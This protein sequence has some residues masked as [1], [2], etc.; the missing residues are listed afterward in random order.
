MTG[1]EVGWLIT[2]KATPAV[3]LASARDA[4]SVAYAI[5]EGLLKQPEALFVDILKR[6][7]KLVPTRTRTSALS[8]ALEVPDRGLEPEIA[9]G[10]IVVVD[11]AEKLEPNDVGFFV[12]MGTGETL[13]RRLETPLAKQPFKIGATNPLF[14]RSKQITAAHKPWGVKVVEVSRVYVAASTWVPGRPV[15]A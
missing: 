2:G 9:A 7:K 11:A 3:P 6:S 12:L 14:E 15:A 5:G 13:A 4:M 1:V 10:D 8:M